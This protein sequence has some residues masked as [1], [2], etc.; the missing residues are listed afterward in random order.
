M[1]QKTRNRVSI[2]LVAKD[3]GFMEGLYK[4]ETQEEGADTRSVQ[5]NQKTDPLT[6]TQPSLFTILLGY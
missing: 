3:E 1:S 2:R 5:G 4:S 6:H